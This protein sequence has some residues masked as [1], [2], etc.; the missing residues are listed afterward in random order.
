M[1]ASPGASHMVV[2]LAPTPGSV[3]LGIAAAY[4]RLGALSE[5]YGTPC[6]R[7][8]AS[9]YGAMPGLAVRLGTR[10]ASVWITASTPASISGARLMLSTGSIWILNVCAVGA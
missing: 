5:G 10:R 9:G 6:L 2:I 1:R 3:S 8:G 4:A 7:V